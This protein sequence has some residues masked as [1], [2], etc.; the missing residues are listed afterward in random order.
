MDETTIE[1]WQAS[2]VWQALYPSINYVY[3]LRT[4]MEKV[5]FT[6]NDKLFVLVCDAFEALH[7]LSNELHYLSCESGVGRPSRKPR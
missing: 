3:R 4:R 1:S 7:A 5:G 2:R 6:P